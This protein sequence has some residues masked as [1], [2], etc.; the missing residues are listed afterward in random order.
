MTGGSQPSVATDGER[1]RGLRWATRLAGLRP[2][3]EARREKGMNKR[4]KDLAIFLKKLQI[5]E[6][7]FK[8]TK[9]MQQ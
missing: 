8:H 4:K 6:F 3:F 1:H 7:E 5:N 9:A 2:A